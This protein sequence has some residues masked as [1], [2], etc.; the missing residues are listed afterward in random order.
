MA[1]ALE[2]QVEIL[3]LHSMEE[4][5]KINREKLSYEVKKMKFSENSEFICIQGNQKLMV[6]K[7][8]NNN[9]YLELEMF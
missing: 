9:Y 5:M 2:N 7:I 3:E 6:C 1:L 8:G 4:K